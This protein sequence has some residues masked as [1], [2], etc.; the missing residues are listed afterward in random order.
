[1]YDTS[2]GLLTVP[3]WVGQS[4]RWGTVHTKLRPSTG[5]VTTRHILNVEGGPSLTLLNG[6][7]LMA[8][9]SL[10]KALHGSNVRELH[11][12]E[13]PDA[14]ARVD[15]EIG[16]ALHLDLPPFGTWQATRADYC[17]QRQLDSEDQVRTSCRALYDVELA[18][19]GKPIVG[20]SGTSV[21]W[22]RGAMKFKVYG[23]LAESDDL[24]ATG[25]LRLEAEVHHQRTFRQLLG[26][27]KGEVVQLLDVL[28]P[29][30]RQLVLQ[31][32]ADV[33]T[34]SV[35]SEKEISD[36]EFV[37]EMVNYFPSKSVARL[38]AFCMM[39]RLAGFPTAR[40]IMNGRTVLPFNKSSVY[41]CLAD[42][43]SFRQHLV[44]H[45]YHRVGIT[46]INPFEDG[47]D[48]LE[49]E[50]RMIEYIGGMDTRRAQGAA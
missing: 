29:E 20:T 40:E 45:G 32:F 31:R 47:L 8:E 6:V 48:E 34:R 11:Q 27:P 24:A 38:I 12:A 49:A 16:E 30:A 7:T 28:T 26:R 39:Y 1:M 37:Q 19:K 43:R 13:L 3:A 46:T 5:E 10:P 33:F 42:L 25:V 14:L 18:R 36:L 21:R 4:P 2:T 23:K 35:M 50:R 22:G 17:E 15:R 9:R 44:D 41:R